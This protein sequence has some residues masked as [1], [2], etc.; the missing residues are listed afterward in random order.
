MA[1]NIGAVIVCHLNHTNYGSCLQAY[2]TIKMVQKFGYNISLIRYTKQRSILDWLKI[3]PKLL[4]S[5][6][7][8]SL[9]ISAKRRSDER[10]Y[11]TYLPNQRIREQATNRFK[12]REFVPLYKEYLGF[13]AL[14]EGSRDYDA[15]FVGSDQVWKPWGFYSYYWNLLFVDDSIPKFSYASSFGVSTIPHIQRRGTGKYLNR[16]DKISVREAKGKEI[17]ESLSDKTATLVADPTML[18]TPEEWREFSQ[19]SNKE[20]PS[21]KYIF[22]YFLGP[23]QE[24]REE[25]KK[26][27]EQ[28]NLKIVIMRHMDEY[29]PIEET[30]GDYAPY[31]IDARAFVK[32]MDN[33]EYVI[34]DSF[35]G[36]VFSILLHKKFTTFYR[37]KPTSGVSTHSRID[38]LLGLFGLTSRKFTGKISDITNDIDFSKVDYCRENLRNKSILFLKQ[39]LKL[40]DK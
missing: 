34:T 12:E 15:V 29:V 14:C 18:F 30:M 3:G 21:E 27:A 20:I 19:S 24:I 1:K 23:R 33:A 4:V 25:A 31:D 5:G 35:H 7:I 40:A 10:K 11:P 39:A 2:A 17:V 6:G 28:L 13:N 22:C 9:Q 36:T 37:V 32:L 16:L 8:E 38:S 26:L